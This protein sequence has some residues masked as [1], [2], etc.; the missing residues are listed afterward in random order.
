MTNPQKARLVFE[1]HRVECEIDSVLLED[2]VTI[3]EMVKI[4]PCYKL[5]R[6]IRATRKAIGW[7]VDT[8]DEESA[9]PM[10]FDAALVFA[11]RW[12]A[13]WKAQNVL[14]N[15]AEDE[16]V[17]AWEDETRAFTL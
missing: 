9:A 4:V 15:A 16:A 10:T 6:M 3:D 7:R 12:L 5:V 13:G 8:P 11:A 17:V 2:I 14:D 1:G